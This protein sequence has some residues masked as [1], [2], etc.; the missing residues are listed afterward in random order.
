MLGHESNFI[1][2]YKPIIFFRCAVFQSAQNLNLSHVQSLRLTVTLVLSL[3]L[4]HFA[5]NKIFENL[6]S[7]LL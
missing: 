3:A 7:S 6:I 1:S 5:V 4:T 2:P